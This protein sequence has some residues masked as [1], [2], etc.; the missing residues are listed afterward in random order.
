MSR[1]GFYPEEVLFS[2]TTDCNLSCGHCDIPKSRKT[3]SAKH[4]DRFL[5][6]CRRVG[7][8]RVG[9]TGGEPFLALDFLCALTKRAVG[10][11]FLF[12]RIMTNAVWWHDENE[13]KCSLVRL[14][15]AGYDG[16]ICVS[17][18]A[19]H[20]QSIRK[21]VRFIELAACI[22]RRSDIVS[23][24][25]T[26][27]AKDRETRAKLNVLNALVKRSD[28]GIFLRTFK[29]EIAPVGRALKFRDPWGGKW[30]K[31][32]YCRGPGNVF[33]VMP[34][35][36]VKPCCGYATDRK[37]L[38][39]GNIKKDSAKDIMKH[40]KENRF[41][42]AVF[43]RGLS[44]IRASL[45][46]AGVRF[47]GKA[48]SHC[49]FCNYI[50]TK[51]PR[52]VLARSLAALVLV[53]IL[54]AQQAFAGELRRGKDYHEISSGIVKQVKI[55]RWYHEGLFYEGKSLWL[56]NGEKGDIWV[57]DPLTGLVTS[58][59][60]P[61]ADFPE[62]LIR[63]EDGTL[64]TTEWYAKKIYRVKLEGGLLVPERESLFEPAH[65]AGLAWNG[66]SLFVVTWTRG[67]GTKFHMIE[68]DRDLKVVNSIRIKNIQEPDQLV[69]DG[70]YL[71]ISS[72]HAK[73]VYK[74]DINKWEIVGYF[75]SPV[76]KTTG[77]AWDGKYMWVTGTYGDLY[78]MEI[79]K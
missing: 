71:W 30:F 41:V 34:D 64:F 55:P 76:S 59:M 29:V 53:F 43:S 6:G 11:G 36:A 13:L 52:G 9:F 70:E 49:H 77:V 16:S 57:I 72:W 15:N 1:K 7:V 38:S 66:K 61:V 54:I 17:V 18:D 8:K 60:E 58:R 42:D 14:F 22:W 65:P 73:T 35:G 19:F 33:F 39:I 37:E 3:L 10:E 56:A 20:R 78:Q 24:A 79:G 74:V 47:P 75:K 4:A 25:Y 12:D 44:K 69:W 27:G 62:A 63:T 48:D 21:V 26:S 45:E 40:L 46:R 50:L 5:I 68:M 23:I 31:E 28:S 2:P 67:M 51:V 32:D